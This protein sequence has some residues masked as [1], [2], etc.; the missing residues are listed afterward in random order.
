MT[1]AVP[2]NEDVLVGV[3]HDINGVYL[4]TK[5]KDDTKAG[6]VMLRIEPEFARTIAQ[7]LTLESIRCENLREGKPSGG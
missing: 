3:A 7:N 2:P 1:E 4:L 6:R 5:D